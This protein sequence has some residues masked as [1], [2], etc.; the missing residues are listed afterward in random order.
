MIASAVPPVPAAITPLPLPVPPVPA[1]ITQLPLPVPPLRAATTPLPL[2]AVATASLPVPP[3]R[4]AP[5][6][7]LCGTTT[8]PFPLPPA[9]LA[10][11]DRGTPAVAAHSPL[12]RATD[13]ARSPANLTVLV[14][15][16]CQPAD[17]RVVQDAHAVRGD[18]IFW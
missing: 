9:A 4:A 11:R 18:A 7:V 3:L 10:G 2:P 15:P 13:T 16:A 6:A 17:G 14:G 1:A 8:V 5:L 12:R